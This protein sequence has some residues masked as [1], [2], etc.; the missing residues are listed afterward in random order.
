MVQR[1]R[2]VRT[3]INHAPR[4]FV[5]AIDNSIPNLVRDA[6]RSDIDKMQTVR[7][8]NDHARPDKRIE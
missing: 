4:A 6:E 3:K 1:R 7:V 5:S 2:I 8:R